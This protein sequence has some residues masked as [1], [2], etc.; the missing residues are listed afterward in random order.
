MGKNPGHWVYRQYTKDSCTFR[1]KLIR[2]G[3]TSTVAPFSF[4]DDRNLLHVSYKTDSRN[5]IYFHYGI[6]KQNVSI[7]SDLENVLKITC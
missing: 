5:C 2:D 6:S 3:L 7:V 1:N 4:V